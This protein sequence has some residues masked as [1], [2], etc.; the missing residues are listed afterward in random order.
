MRSGLSFDLPVPPSRKA[1]RA[2]TG[3][4]SLATG[5]GAA[6]AGS[7]DPRSAKVAAKRLAGTALGPEWIIPT[8]WQ[9]TAFPA[10][11]PFAVPA[12]LQAR[13]GC[14]QY[15]VLCDPPGAPPRRRHQRLARRWPRAWK[16][17]G[18]GKS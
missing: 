5:A 17:V 6:T 14:H 7:I 9:G 10:E 8:L 15:R 13:H 16:S 1:R 2:A 11:I 12:I 3:L 18:A 4:R